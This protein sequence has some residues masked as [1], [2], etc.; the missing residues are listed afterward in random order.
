[1]LSF[2][3]L[4]DLPAA[5][6]ELLL[7]VPAGRVTTFGAV[8]RAL[9]DV[10]AARWVAQYLGDIAAA[11]GTDASV[12]WHRV[13]RSDG[14]LAK[15]SADALALQALRIEDEGVTVGDGTV[16]L[17]TCGFAPSLPRQPLAPLQQFQD[18]VARRVSCELRDP[19]MLLVGLDVAYPRGGMGVAAAVVLDALS[20][21]LVAE[22]R[23][24]LPVPFPYLPGYLL[25][26]ELPLLLAVWV[27]VRA[28]IGRAP[29]LCLVDG[30]G[31]LHPRRAGVAC[32]FGV[33][34]DVPTVGV[35]KSLLCGHRDAAAT[36]AF[37][38][39]PVRHQG[40]TIGLAL[41]SRSSSR[42]LYVSVGHACSLNFAAAWASGST[43]G[44][45]LPEPVHLAD[46][47]TRRRSP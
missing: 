5:V 35:S 7:Q 36:D 19:P 27:Q 20:L 21:E 43:R 34:A 17:A 29:V 42:P 10:R 32:G 1:M 31:R 47:L 26:R 18:E 30:N 22:Y 16:S 15:A 37:G 9:G 40:E 45:R 14:R 8:A 33:L 3:A 13:V 39:T 4:P 12:P 44:H 46:R 2:P 23:C 41:P 28:A 25:F 38:R 24:E 6:R 11:R